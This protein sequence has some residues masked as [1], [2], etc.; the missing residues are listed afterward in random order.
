MNSRTPDFIEAFLEYCGESECPQPYL[1][2]AAFSLLAACCGNRIFLPYRIGNQPIRIYPNLYVM[3]LGPTANYKSFTVSR[4]KE[5]LKHV[6]YAGRLHVFSGHITSSGMYDEMQTARKN[7]KGETVEL[8]GQSQ[9]YLI[10]EE[11][12]N[13]VGNPEYADALI[14]ALTDLYHLGAFSDRTRTSGLAT[15]ENYSINWLP[16][17]TIDW[18]LLAIQRHTLMGGIFGRLITVNCDYTNKRIYPYDSKKPVDWD[19]LFNYLTARLDAVLDLSGPIKL[20]PDAI[21]VDRA[22]YMSRP[23]PIGNDPTMRSSKRQ[24]DLSLKLGMLLAI[25]REK[26]LVDDEML[27]EAQD[28]TTQVVAWQNEILPSIE[29][30]THGAPHDRILQYILQRG[31]IAHTALYKYVYDKYGIKSFEA[32]KLLQ[33]W[34]EAGHLVE[35]PRPRSKGGVL[36]AAPASE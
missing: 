34:L 32:D 12:A 18:L 29:K 9:F 11:L 14:K 36:Y 13:A 16:C 10:Q 4:I 21:R 8:G 1:K 3:L 2:W 27:A 15:L 22:W 25:S 26:E 17:T 28:L 35:L 23:Q 6:N 20:T 19:I 31:Q 24:H 30:G 33:T 7:R 5:V